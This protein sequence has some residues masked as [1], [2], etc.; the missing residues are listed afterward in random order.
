[1]TALTP[2]TGPST[3]LITIEELTACMHAC[4]TAGG[5]TPL[6]LMRVAPPFLA[7][8]RFRHI[9]W[10]YH[11]PPCVVPPLVVCLMCHT[12]VVQLVPQST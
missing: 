11:G 2:G 9:S 8:S 7:T 10:S 5:F 4:P 3:E 6:M 1:M 12:L